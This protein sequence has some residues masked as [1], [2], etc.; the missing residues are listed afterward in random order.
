MILKVVS[1]KKGHC[2][3]FAVSFLL[4]EKRRKY[5]YERLK[6]APAQITPVPHVQIY[7]N[8]VL[9]CFNEQLLDPCGHVG[10]VDEGTVLKR[11]AQTAEIKVGRTH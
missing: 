1:P 6:Y 4:L 10:V 3:F 5:A 2:I 7:L 9:T 11:L 8:A